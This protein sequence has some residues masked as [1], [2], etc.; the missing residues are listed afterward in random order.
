MNENPSDRPESPVSSP[1]EIDPEIEKQVEEELPESFRRL[2]E[3]VRREVFSKVAIS[4]SHSTWDGSYPPPSILEGYEAIHKGLADR[5]VGMAESDLCHQHKMDALLA[6]YM[7]RGQWFG[8]IL[9]LTAIV[10]SIYLISQD[11]QIAGAILGGAVIIPLV[12]LFV[13]GQL[14]FGGASAANGDQKDRSEAESKPSNMV[15]S[16]GKRPSTR[17]KKSQSRPSS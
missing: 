5:V 1:P 15:K 6:G 10:G 8:F 14:R 2:P 9:A 4:V 17:R 3:D 7:T 13:R 12:T 16:K 11:R